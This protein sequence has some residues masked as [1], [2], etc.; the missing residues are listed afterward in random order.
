V[1]DIFSKYNEKQD[2]ELTEREF[3]NIMFYY[4]IDQFVRKTKEIIRLVDPRKGLTIQKNDFLYELKIQKE[5]F[6]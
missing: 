1:D 3:Q 4:N 2:N 6:D 5:D